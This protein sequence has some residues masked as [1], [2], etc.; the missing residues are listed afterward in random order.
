[1]TNHERRVPRKIRWTLTAALAGGSLFGPCEVRLRDAVVGGS[2]D[3]VSSLLTS[4]EVLQDLFPFFFPP[5][6]SGSDA[7]TGE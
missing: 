6:D 2:K 3:F 7:T 1:M 4:E 5:S